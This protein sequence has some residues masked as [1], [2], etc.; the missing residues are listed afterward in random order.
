MNFRG[1]MVCAVVLLTASHVFAQNYEIRL[2][3]DVRAGEKYELA[4]SGSLSEQM[5]M[6][7]QGQVLHKDTTS[8]TAKLEGTVTVL[9]VDELKR[10]RKLSL[11]V[12]RCLMSTNGST[13]EK[14]VLAKDTQ[15][16]AQLRD[17][18]MEFLIDGKVVSK[19][20]AK[21]LGL[22]ISL[23]TSQT[24][25]DDIFGTKERKK[26]G[27]SWAVNSSKGA[28]DLS[29]EG[30]K[31]NA[32]DIK[33][34]TKID[35]LLVV[36]G[37]NC[38]QLSSRMEISNILPPLPEGLTVTES[39]MS[40]TFTGEFPVDVSMRQMSEGITMSMVLVAKGKPIPDAPEITLS[41][42]MEESK[43]AKQKSIK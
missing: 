12:S 9:E 37:T 43:H 8:I 40:A 11:V 14:E 33:G 18:Q 34:S 22:L 41:M 23:P 16:V 32:D 6:L 20:I 15:V 4:A 31:V 13:V 30:I 28:A 42:N 39:N 29:F 21:M 24:T 2:T 19:D 27:D 17:G 1:V 26:V 35:K 5:T 3:R 7:A 36:G 38:L 10:E 25:D